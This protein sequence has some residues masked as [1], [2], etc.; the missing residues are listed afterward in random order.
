MVVPSRSLKAPAAFSPASM[1]LSPTPA[2]CSAASIK[3]PAFT[4]APILSRASCASLAESCIVLSPVAASL[5]PWSISFSIETFCLI[6]LSKRFKSACAR[7]TVCCHFKV[8]VSASPYFF[9][10]SSSPFCKS[11]NFRFCASICLFKTSF[12]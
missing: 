1:I 7:F 6:V 10:L 9:A 3:F 8:F 4:P 5:V 11:S 2:I 12:F